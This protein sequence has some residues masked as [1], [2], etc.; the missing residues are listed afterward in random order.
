MKIAQA[1]GFAHQAITFYLKLY[2]V[3]D[4]ARKKNLSP[5]A[6]YE[7]CKKNSEPVL[8]AFKKWLD[9]RLTKTSD[10]IFRSN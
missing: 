2:A 7:L 9:H 1:P 6:R 3:E 10:T 5:E 4:E 8:E